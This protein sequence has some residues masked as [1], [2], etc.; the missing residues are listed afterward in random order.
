ML[1]KFKFTGP[2]IIP[3][4]MSSKLLLVKH[5]ILVWSDL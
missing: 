4:I 1:H 3:F 2:F 5:D